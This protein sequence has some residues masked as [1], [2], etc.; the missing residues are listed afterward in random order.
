MILPNP[1]SE[2][3][4]EGN[5]AKVRLDGKY[6]SNN[7][8]M[9]VGR[10]CSEPMCLEKLRNSLILSRTSNGLHQ[11]RPVDTIFFLTSSLYTGCHRE[12]VAGSLDRKPLQ[13][14]DMLRSSDLSTKSFRINCCIGRSS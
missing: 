7:I 1:N 2:P 3:D 8:G 4:G 13:H 14:N 12:K 5:H 9:A 11:D 10:V 6:F